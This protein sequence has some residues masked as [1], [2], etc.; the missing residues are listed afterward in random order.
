M[1]GDPGD[2]TFAP[3]YGEF[4]TSGGGD[5][6]ALAL[7]VPTDQDRA[8]CPGLDRVRLLEASTAAYDA[9]CA[10]TAGRRRAVGARRE[11]RLEGD[12][13]KDVPRLVRPVLGRPYAARRGRDDPRRAAQAAIGVARRAHDLRL[14]YRPTDAVDLLRLDTWLARMLLDARR[15]DIT[16]SGATSSRSTTSATGCATSSGSVAAPKVDLA[17]EELLDAINEGDLATAREVPRGE[18]VKQD[19]VIPTRPTCR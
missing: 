18:V 4:Y 1:D 12:R 15:R 14:R 7:A 13:P 5:T 2:K 9:A 6:E 8:R 17:L 11:G 16:R 19:P 3:G 10:A